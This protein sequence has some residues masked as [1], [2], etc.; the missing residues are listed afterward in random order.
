M[1]LLQADEDQG[2]LGVWSLSR[3]REAS[4]LDSV[5]QDLIRVPLKISIQNIARI[6]NPS[7]LRNELR[8]GARTLRQRRS[9]GKTASADS[10][11]NALVFAPHT[12]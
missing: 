5:K 1:L 8:D 7:L 10:E 3:L 4:F 12:I 6:L 11:M 9:G 2:H